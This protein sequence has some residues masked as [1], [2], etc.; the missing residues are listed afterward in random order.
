MNTTTGKVAPV[1]AFVGGDSFMRGE[2]LGQILHALS[3]DSDAFGPS[4]V[5][6]SRARLAEVLDDIRTPSLLG[7]CRVVIVEDA[8]PFISAHRQALERYCSSPSP[9]GVLVFLCNS[10]P[11]NTKLARI[12]EEHG[13]VK[14]LEAPRGRAITEWIIQRART[15]YGKRLG[16][17]SAASLRRHIGDTL[18]G[19]DAELAKLAAFVG[20]RGEIAGADIDGLTGHQREERVFAVTDAIISKDTASALRHWEQVLATDR[21]AP[22]RA[23]GGLAWGVRQMLE[24]RRGWEEGIGVGD[25]ARQLR[26]NP[27]VLRMRLERTTTAQLESQQRD[28]LAADLAVKTGAS[29][30]EIAIEKFIVKHSANG[31]STT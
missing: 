10:L 28:L 3:A 30:V 19:L 4:R 11:R 7:G 2:A 20:E 13:A 6:G 8:D 14:K 25:L 1:L 23:I 26:T 17:E 29:T 22:A 5:D 24:A 9:T 31:P 12:I 18:G 16:Q 27:E 15:T 21:A